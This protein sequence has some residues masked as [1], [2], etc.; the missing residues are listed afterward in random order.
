MEYEALL[1]TTLDDICWMTNL[2]GTDIDYNPVF[3]SYMLFLPKCSET[4]I[5]L[6]TD[7]AKVANAQEYLAS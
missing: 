6:F 3:F 1:V 4:R 5:I 7:D 2:R